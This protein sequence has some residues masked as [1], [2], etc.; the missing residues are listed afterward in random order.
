MSVALMAPAT[1]PFEFFCHERHNIQDVID[2]VIDGYRECDTTRKLPPSLHSIGYML[3]YNYAYELY[4]RAMLRDD[5]IHYGS[6]KD[7]IEEAIG[8]G[9]AESVEDFVDKSMDEGQTFEMTSY[10]AELFYNDIEYALKAS[11]LCFVQVDDDDEGTTWDYYE[12]GKCPSRKF[13][14]FNCPL[15]GVW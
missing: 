15:I 11:N 9:D 13:K 6:L 7:E 8:N 1:Y 2:L 12:G 3:D 5:V 4:H 14:V 10:W